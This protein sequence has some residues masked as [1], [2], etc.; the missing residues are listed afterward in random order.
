MDPRQG[1]GRPPPPSALDPVVG[2]RAEFGAAVAV[3]AAKGRRPSPPGASDRS[4]GLVPKGPPLGLGGGAAF[5][6]TSDP[7][8]LDE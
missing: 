7:P 2:G 4:S 6:G 8:N 5:P 1:E 3:E